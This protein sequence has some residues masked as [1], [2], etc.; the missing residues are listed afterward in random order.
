MLVITV[1]DA[2]RVRRG[3]VGVERSVTP[4][5]SPVVRLVKTTGV[6]TW[7]L[8][9]APATRYADIVNVTTALTAAG[10]SLGTILP[11]SD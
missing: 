6:Q 9:V 7:D 5:F 2:E 10:L 1:F 11:G 4:D 8:Q 3:V